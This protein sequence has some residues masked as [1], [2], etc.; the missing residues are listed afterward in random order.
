MAASACGTGSINATVDKA[1][2]RLDPERH[3][4]ELADGLGLAGAGVGLLT[5]VDVG[6][7][8][9]ADDG[10]VTAVA[11]VGLGH[12]TWAAAPDGDLRH[13]PAGTI[14]IV[15]WLPVRLSDAALVNAVATATEAKAQALWDCGH[16]S[17]R[18]GQRCRIYRLPGR[19]RSGRAVSAVRGRPGARGWPGPCTRRWV[20][21]PA[22]GLSL[23][24]DE[25][26]HGPARHQLASAGPRHPPASA[27]WPPPQ[28]WACL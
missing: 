25:A 2:A 3:L 11:T 17:N 14:N 27:R 12:P 16:Q 7:A 23:Q 22:G 15:A 26:V 5:A 1:Y 6:D 19:R 18:Y 9:T 13:E 4:G 24:P 10:G 21:A 20:K 28:R 8:V